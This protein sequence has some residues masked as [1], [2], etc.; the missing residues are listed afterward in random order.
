[1]DYH[2]IIEVNGDI[3]AGIRKLRK[4]WIQSGLRRELKDREGF[5][6]RTQRRRRKD[7]TA[8][9][10]LRKQARKKQADAGR[11]S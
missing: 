8:L 9:R 10:R 7:A 1:M 3:E 4:Y 5:M 2:G 6:S 11:Y